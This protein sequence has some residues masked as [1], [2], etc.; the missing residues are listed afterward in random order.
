MIESVVLTFMTL[1]TDYKRNSYLANVIPFVGNDIGQLVDINEQNYFDGFS[2]IDNVNKVKNQLF[3]LLNQSRISYSVYNNASNL[4]VNLP[5]L[6]LEKIDI[7]NVFESNYGTLMVD[8]ELKNNDLFSLEIGKKSI[9]YFSE[10]DDVTY[11]Y[12]DELETVSEDGRVVS[13]NKL[14]EDLLDFLNYQSIA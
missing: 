11:S 13:P 7:D 2:K 5:E 3:S 14:S 12:C 9:G 6:V 10:V 4:L 8:F 1:S